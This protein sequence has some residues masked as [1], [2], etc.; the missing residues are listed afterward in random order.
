MPPARSLE[1]SCP[2][3]ERIGCGRGRCCRRRAGFL[4]WTRADQELL[5]GGGRSWGSRKG[6]G[7]WRGGVCAP[8]LPAKGSSSQGAPAAPVPR[9]PSW[10]PTER[11]RPFGTGRHHKHP[12][13][14]VWHVMQHPHV[15]TWDLGLIHDT[16]LLS[17]PNP[18]CLNNPPRHTQTTLSPSTQLAQNAAT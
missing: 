6:P 9:A 4:T 5:G 15:C 13:V 8:L 3:S 11:S 12:G 1:A 18:L 2:G 14:S 16:H 17:H 10:L 7:G